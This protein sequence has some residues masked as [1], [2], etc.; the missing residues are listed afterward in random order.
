MTGSAVR[1][2]E[3][4]GIKGAD[5]NCRVCTSGSLQFRAVSLGG[6]HLRRLSVGGIGLTVC[7]KPCKD[8]AIE[9]AAQSAS[10][11]PIPANSAT[12]LIPLKILNHNAKASKKVSFC[13]LYTQSLHQ[14]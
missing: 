9:R 3:V 10:R 7:E 1:E 12:S 11:A 14:N 13:V 6:E 2:R 4:S 8:P 5:V